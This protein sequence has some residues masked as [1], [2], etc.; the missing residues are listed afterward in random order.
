MARRRATPRAKPSE[1]TA[2]SDCSHR[3]CIVSGERLARDRLIR[4][5]L[6]PD[7][8]VVP[9]LAARLPGRGLWVRSDRRSLDEA[10]RRKRFHHAARGQVVVVPDLA[11]RVGD[12]LARRALEYLGLARRAGELVSG[13]EKTRQLIEAGHCAVLVQA[14]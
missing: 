6:G 12:L 7:G 10:V 1:A 5:V 11:D 9:D 13:F 2:S 3:R 4:F 14:L 8:D